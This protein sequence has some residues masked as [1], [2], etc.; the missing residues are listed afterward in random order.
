MIGWRVNY[1]KCVQKQFFRN[2]CD[3]KKSPG[4]RQKK[5]NM[6]VR[7]GQTWCDIKTGATFGVIK[8]LVEFTVWYKHKE[9]ATV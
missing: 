3:R 6:R 7:F 8:K 2:R 4:K 1:Y 9:I 5:I